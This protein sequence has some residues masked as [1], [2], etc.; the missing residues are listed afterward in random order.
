MITSSLF[1]GDAGGVEGDEQ[2]EHEHG[3][4]DDEEEPG[5]RR[6]GVVEGLADP[7]DGHRR[8]DTVD[9]EQRSLD[10]V[11]GRRTL[12]GDGYQVG[13]TRQPEEFGGRIVVEVGEGADR[14]V[15]QGADPYVGLD[16]LQA[17]AR[18]E[19]VSD[20]DRVARSD[21]EVVGGLVGDDE[22]VSGAGGDVGPGRP[23]GGL[24]VVT[25]DQQVER[26]VAVTDRGRGEPEAEV[27]GPDEG[28]VGDRADAR[29]P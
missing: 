3:D 25:V 4:G 29:R 1:D 21:A 12:G 9:S 15:V 17:L 6:Q 16:E 18:A 28:I 23:D 27:G 10:L 24:E 20:P 22:A 5:E 19:R 26:V 13:Q 2:C 11:G 8:G 7:R 14:A